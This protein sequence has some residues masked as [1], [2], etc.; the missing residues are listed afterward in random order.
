MNSLAR[1]SIS[2]LNEPIRVAV[3]GSCGQ[4]GYALIYRIAS[5]A[6]FGPN[7][8]VIL[9][10]LEVPQMLDKLKGVQMELEDC[11]FP[12]LKGIV[13]T[14]KPE[15]AFEGVDWALLVGAK[16]RGPGMERGDLLMQNAEIFSVQGKALNKVGKGKNTRV[17]VVGN[18][19]NTNAMICQRSA[20]NIPPQ[21]FG[22]MTKLDHNR[23]LAQLSKKLN[24]FPSEIKKFVIWGNHSATQFPDVTF[25]TVDNKKISD[26]VDKKWLV[27]SFIP[28]VQ[29]RG[30]E[31]IAARGLSSAASAG[32]SL[33]DN[34]REWFSG[35]FGDWTSVAVH[36]NGE[37]GITPGLFYSYPVTF[38]QQQ[39]TI[40]KDLP[41]D[42]F[43]KER[44]E[45]THKELL[46]ERDAVAK[47]LTK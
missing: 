28:T 21:N 8:P 29:K 32:S 4:I 42:N 30:A 9:H 1:S 40:I 12:N 33:I 24:V 39:F 17:L 15:V 23:G 26:S 41:I 10:L 7:T 18:P 19:A 22:A 44:M 14:D 46:S 43:Q 38:S 35:T 13:L 34:V 25:A 36:S 5:G 6:A 3:T 37:Y 47:L 2:D 27:D 31:I 16:P 11:A 20:P 45:S